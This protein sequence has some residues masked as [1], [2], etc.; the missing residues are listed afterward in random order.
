MGLLVGIA[1]L[2]LTAV[3]VGMAAWGK[4]VSGP[5]RVDIGLTL[6]LAGMVS[7]LGWSLLSRFP[8]NPDRKPRREI[9][10]LLGER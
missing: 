3:R 8:V 2:F 4:T 5:I 7:S 9:T 10:S 6:P 1:W